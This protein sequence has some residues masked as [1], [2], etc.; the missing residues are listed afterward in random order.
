M[1]SGVSIELKS[2]STYLVDLR[3]WDMLC[4]A[5]NE[6]QSGWVE[7]DS[8]WGDGKMMLRLQDIRT[9]FWASGRYCDAREAFEKESAKAEAIGD[10]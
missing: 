9:I 6:N 4:A 1:Q 10:V 3:H 5:L 7:L 8:C 2:K